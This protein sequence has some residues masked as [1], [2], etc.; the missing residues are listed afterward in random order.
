MSIAAAT[1]FHLLDW[2]VLC[3]YLAIV[4]AIGVGVS[5]RHAG[6]DEFFLAGRGMPMWA[7][8]ISVLATSLSAATYIGG[9]QQAYE[10]NLT[11][12]SANIGGLAALIVVAVVFIPAFYRHRVTTVYEL[13]GHTCGATARRAASAMFM[14]GRVFASGARLFMVA[15][16]FALI[17]FG[18][19]RPAHLIAS[20]L[21]IALGATLYTT[22]GGIRA[23]IWTDVLQAV[24]LVVTVVIALA[25]LAAKIP[26]S[27]AQ[28]AGALAE[29]AVGDTTKLTVIDL[30]TDGS[31]WY[32]LWTA[33]TGWTL[34][35]LAAF[36]T[37]Q[38]LAQRMLTCRSARAGGWSAVLSNLIGW[39]VVGLFLVLGLL[40][41][42]FYQRPELMGSAAPAYEIDDSRKV[43][44]EFILHEIGP[45]FRGLMM[46]GL[47]AA[48]MS[49]L[50]SAL[51]AMAST[52]IADFYRPWRAARRGSAEV[53]AGD[54]RRASRVAVLLWALVLAGF[55]CGCVFWQVASGRTLI[56]FALGVMVFAY[57]GLL[58][59]FLTALFTPRGNAA[60][61]VAALATGFVCVLLMGDSVAMP[62]QMVIATAL[63]FGVCCLGRRRSAA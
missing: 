21:I 7:V 46:A 48:A 28:I 38:D 51:N 20:I 49:S 5:R 52:A 42:V 27:A 23:V 56:D 29:T 47:F 35:N 57:A 30:G 10:T 31:K 45:G 12:L 61:V 34:F 43:F 39:P 44:L 1:S 15:L 13:L 2:I 62:W 59:V 54:D 4:V 9:P 17:T 8:A 32:T 33:L 41:Y 25:V 37:D 40:L 14:I 60:S 55:A 16:P 58:G 11:Y 36:G 24:L 26:L 18:D 3:A 19:I 53:D 22:A 50:D 63:S 6:R